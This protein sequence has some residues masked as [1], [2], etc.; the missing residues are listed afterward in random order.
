MAIS[1]DDLARIGRMLHGSNWVVPLAN[2]LRI[3]P[4]S[5]Q[6]MIAGDRPIPVGL[7]RDLVALIDAQR[8]EIARALGVENGPHDQSQAVQTSPQIVA[9]EQN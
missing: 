2:D 4:R 8:N 7:G 9:G 3:N 5:L 1:S 6:R